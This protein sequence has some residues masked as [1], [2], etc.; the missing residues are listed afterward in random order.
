MTCPQL[1]SACVFCPISK[2]P[3]EVVKRDYFPQFSRD[4]VDIYSALVFGVHCDD[5]V[6]GYVEKWL[7][8]K[9]R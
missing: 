9:V 4:I 3:T 2:V 1:T 7:P 8:R 6:C 5:V